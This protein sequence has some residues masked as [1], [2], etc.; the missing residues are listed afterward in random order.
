M[1]L[2]VQYSGMWTLAQQYQAV[3]ANTWKNIPQ[4]EMYSWGYNISGGHGDNTRIDKSS[5]VQIGT[6]VDWSLVS[7]GYQHTAAIKQNGTLWGWGKNSLGAVGDN[8]AVYRSSPVQIGTGTTWY[9]VSSSTYNNLAT[10]TDGTIWSW[11]RSDFGQ[12]G[13]NTVINKSSPVQIGALTTWLTLNSGRDSNFNIKSDGTLWAWGYNTFGGLGQN[14]ILHRSSPVQIGAGVYAWTQFA[15]GTNHDVGIQSNGS[16][17]SFGYNTF[18]QLGQ[19]DTADRSSPVQI[20][21]S[22]NWSKVA[23]GN[24]HQL[25][26]KTDGALWLWGNSNYGQL[27]LNDVIGR[28]SPVQLGALTTWSKVSAGYSTLAIK[29]DGTLWAWGNN[30]YGQLGDSTTANKSSPVQIG[31]LTTWSQTSSSTS[32][33]SAAIKTDGTLWTW[34]ANFYGQLGLNNQAAYRSS[35]TQVGAATDWYQV[36]WSTTFVMSV[37]TNGTLWGWGRNL[38][39]NLGDNT[40]ITRSSPVQVGALTSWALVTPGVYHSIAVK[41][42]GTLWAWGHNDK[43]QSGINTVVYRSSPI[44]VGSLATW[45]TT[46]ARGQFSTAIDTSGILYTF[47]YNSNGQ[48]GDST[49]ANRSSPVQI[50]STPVAETNNWSQVAGGRHTLALKTNNSLW[51]W[52]NNGDGYLGDNTIINRSSPVQIGNTPAAETNNWSLIGSGAYV[53]SAIKTDGTLWV[54]GQNVGGELGQNNIV[55]KSSPVQVGTDTNW[56]QLAEGSASL[57]LVAIKTNGSLYAWGRNTRGQLGDNTTIYR[58]SPVQ[59]GALTTWARAAT[60]RLHSAA[61]K[62]DGTLWTFGYNQVG[63]I[64]DNTT[65]YR[66]SPVQVGALTTWYQLTAGRFHTVATKTDGTLW[67]FG[68]NG[69]GQLGDNTI[70][71]RSSPVQVGALTTW[72]QVAGGH[73]HTLAIKTNGTMWSWG[74]NNNAQLGQNDIN[75]DR[76]SPTQIGALTT[77]S[78]VKAGSYFNIALKT[79]GTLW[80]WGANNRGQIGD[81]TVYRRS[82]PVQIGA[83]TNW[84]QISAS[85]GGNRAIKTNGTLYGW[86]FNTQGESVSDG[87]VEPRS[88]PVQVGTYVEAWSKISAGSNISLAT[89]AD[90]TLWAFGYNGQGDLGVNDRVNRSSP[91][92]VG[93]LSTWSLIDGAIYGKNSAAIKTDGTLWIWGNNQNGQVGNNTAINRSSPVQVGTSTNW[94][95]VS[96]GGNSVSAITRRLT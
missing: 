23:A 77:W 36:S 45:S 85:N 70:L 4:Y 41:T 57:F 31:A 22:Y 52:G 51:A 29:T 38:Y 93:A 7:V 35:P 16:L 30:P 75:A 54:A 42:D 68:Y 59:V 72:S 62:T 24:N 28:S 25:A 5:P 74:S 58:S 76:S 12:V 56:S 73:Y 1:P 71:N 18:G 21:S 86:G 14:N 27:G 94:Y 33:N 83:D 63:M 90:G 2:G 46:S 92:Q 17:W 13:D 88:S 66:S 44:Q 78:K 82:S 8:T 50:G 32:A 60:G 67:T 26:I 48:L 55:Y 81:N 80:T 61:V 96:V 10:K 84:S 47:G 64:G 49:R 34:G 39:G 9:L 53:T 69:S 15:T 89:K 43:G 20:G 6:G 87:T 65:I 19:N 95:Q 3:G 37:K 11:G 79:D 91:V 40:N